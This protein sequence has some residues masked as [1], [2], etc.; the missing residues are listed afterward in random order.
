MGHLP[1]FLQVAAARCLIVGGGEVAQRKAQSLLDAGADVAVISPAL[2]PGLEKHARAGRIRHISRAYV[3][4]DMR[5]HLLVFAATDDATLHKAL[6]EEARALSIPINV[7]DEPELC[8]FIMPA[9]VGRG[10]LTIAVSTAGASPAMAK[11]IAGRI[12]RIFGPEYGVALEIIRAA[13]VRL[14]DRESSAIRR[15]RALSALAA[16]RLAALV[17]RGD[18][19]GIERVLRRHVGAGLEELGLAPLQSGET[20]AAR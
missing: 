15:S 12:E 16:S 6:C 20:Q 3:L 17:R 5:G 4:G 7:A 10:A 18:V 8:S 1:I 2:T 19:A 9:I 13:R 11:R 14:R